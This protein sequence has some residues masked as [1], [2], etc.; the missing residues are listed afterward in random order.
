LFYS[1]TESQ[2]NCILKWVYFV[3]DGQKR[4]IAAK[5]LGKDTYPARVVSVTPT[6]IRLNETNYDLLSQRKEDGLWEGVLSVSLTSDG[7]FESGKAEI[8]RYE[9]IWVFAKNMPKTK[10]IY[11]QLGASGQAE[12]PF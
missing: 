5:A 10:E 3:V 6:E 2:I 4:I 8:Y 1:A 9:G 12:I 11:Q 7:R